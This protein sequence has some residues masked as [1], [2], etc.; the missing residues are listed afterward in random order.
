MAGEM[1][2][3]LV[4]AQRVHDV[5]PLIRALLG[6]S[7][8]S[9][10]MAPLL[11]QA[12]AA[13]ANNG[14]RRRGGELARV[15]RW[16]AIPPRYFLSPTGLNAAAHDALELLC[17]PDGGAWTLT[18]PFGHGWAVV[19]TSQLLLQEQPTMAAVFFDG[20]TPLIEEPALG[21]L[22]AGL[23]PQDALPA[24]A[25]EAAH[26]RD[27]AARG[28]VDPDLPYE[29]GEIEGLVKVIELAGSAPNW[30]LTYEFLL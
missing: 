13:S 17:F 25:A 11:D 18:E 8:L 28:D 6:G 20:A 27:V 14:A 2:V 30:S 12:V 21:E 24:L 9:A 19:E 3:R 10:D 7:I 15:K 1:L 16:A 4:D 26:V 23:V 5:A 29:L 22:C